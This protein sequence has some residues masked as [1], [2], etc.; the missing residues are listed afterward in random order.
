MN[1]NFLDQAVFLPEYFLHRKWAMRIFSLIVICCISLTSCQS[2]GPLDN[3]KEKHL[4]NVRQLTFGGQNA[5]A[6][7]SFQGDRL[8]FQSTR[9]GISCDQIFSM[10]INGS[11]VKLLSTGKGRT[12]CGYYYPDGKQI[13][14][15]STHHVDS[16]CPP[17]PDRSKGYVWGLYD[18][19]LYLADASGKNER[20]L[21]GSSGYDAE[22]TISPDGKKMV[23][24]SDKDGDLEIYIMNLDGTGLKRLTH[25]IGYD[26]GAFFSPNSQQIV[27]RAHYPKD[28]KAIADYQRLLKDHLVRP[29][30]MDIFV[31][32][33]DGTNVHQLTNNGK[34]NFAP[35]WH[36]SGK[37]ILFASN[38][39]DPKRRNFDM[40]LI[41]ADGTD[42]EQ[43]TFDPTFD[44]FPM[45]SPDGKSLVFASNRHN[46]VRG[47][48]NVFI[49]DWV[50]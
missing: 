6:Y 33:V 19:D 46:K 20:K 7:Y 18:Y 27:F 45:F 15:A 11:N 44:G 5:E 13:V 50:E 28:P 9:D 14:Y 8:I 35:Y 34:A 21:F 17:S 47:E 49:A 32:D 48:T 12:T 30:Q 42:L 38:M 3:P 2:R 29:S 23:F 22:A 24:T 10:N 43:V 26:G 40:F 4:R 41:N 16:A 37:K 1:A 39:N 31:M 36:P 25:K